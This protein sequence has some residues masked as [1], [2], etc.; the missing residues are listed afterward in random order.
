[1]VDVDELPDGSACEHGALEGGNAFDE[2][3]IEF[4]PF[5]S[6]GLQREKDLVG[7]VSL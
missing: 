2:H 6:V 4:V 7:A 1:M 3:L 5:R